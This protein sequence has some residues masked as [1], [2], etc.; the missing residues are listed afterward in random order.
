MAKTVA[1]IAFIGACAVIAGYLAQRPT[2]AR[3][4]ALAAE[5]QEDQSADVTRIECDDARIGPRGAK[6]M[7]RVE[8]ATRGTG[9]V[10]CE[11]G[12]DGRIACLGM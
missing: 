8:T 4:D 6:F 1:T 7:C 11:L 3:G 9:T 2:I 5:L 12:R 10:A